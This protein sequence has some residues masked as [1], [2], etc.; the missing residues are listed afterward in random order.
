MGPSY[1]HSHSATLPPPLPSGQWRSER[2]L[3]GPPICILIR[4]HCRLHCPLGSGVQ[5]DT[6]GALLYAF[7]F[8][9]IA[10]STALWA[11]AF[12]TIP[13]GPSYMHSHSA[14]LPPPLPSGQWRSERY[15]WG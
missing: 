15:L 11:V 8:G 14:T 12:R 3:W 6:Y 2:Y 10:A 1:M 9:D 4:R 13:M 5:N 7:S